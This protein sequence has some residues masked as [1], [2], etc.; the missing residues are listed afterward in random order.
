MPFWFQLFNIIDVFWTSVTNN[1][2]P[3]K[4]RNKT[5]GAY[6][7]RIYFRIVDK[8][9]VGKI[10]KW[11]NGKNSDEPKN[12]NPN[13]ELVTDWTSCKIWKIFLI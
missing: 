10:S 1:N 12:K 5:W 3:N 6:N 13:L 2:F 8:N 4:K 11:K 7:L 9:C